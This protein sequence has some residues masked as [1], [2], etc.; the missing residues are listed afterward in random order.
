M[1]RTTLCLD[2]DVCVA[3]DDVWR[4]WRM[5]RCSGQGTLKVPLALATGSQPRYW[6]PCRSTMCIHRR[7][8]R[9][10]ARLR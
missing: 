2:A 5:R 1:L 4:A 8:C 9:A 6:Q 7:S 3:C 10:W